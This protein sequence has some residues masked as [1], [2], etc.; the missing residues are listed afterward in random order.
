[1][2]V[3]NSPAG[4]A[5]SGG[6]ASMSE[7]HVAIEGAPAPAL[8]ARTIAQPQAGA[9]H[10][11]SGPVCCTLAGSGQLRQLQLHQ[12]AAAAETGQPTAAQ[13]SPRLN[14]LQ[15]GV[16]AATEQER[17]KKECAEGVVNALSGTRHRSH[18]Q[19]MD[20]PASTAAVGRVPVVEVSIPA[21]APRAVPHSRRWAAR[22]TTAS[23]QTALVHCS[24]RRRTAGRLQRTLRGFSR[25][26]LRK[27]LEGAA[28]CAHRA[29]PREPRSWRL[30]HGVG[31]PAPQ[32]RIANRPWS[33]AASAGEQPENATD[34]A[35]LA[36]PQVTVKSEDIARKQAGWKM[37]I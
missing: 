15:H 23:H 11:P 37:I 26:A 5:T 7:R 20:K 19:R 2:S 27:L 14:Q 34:A 9:Q 6:D 17:R 24:T 35:R 33:A 32:R 31:K 3:L 36:R 25:T 4:D 28:H 8:A 29:P 16:G 12:R 10:P 1:M 21:R 13:A 30:V 18:S 22:P